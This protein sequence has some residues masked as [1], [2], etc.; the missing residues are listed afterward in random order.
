MAGMKTPDKP[1]H[2]QIHIINVKAVQALGIDPE[3]LSHGGDQEELARTLTRI[4]SYISSFAADRMAKFIL[5]SEGDWD[6]I[7]EDKQVANTAGCM[8]LIEPMLDELMS[9]G[10][11]I[12]WVEDLE[13][14]FPIT[15]ENQMA[16]NHD[17]ARVAGIEL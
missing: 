12:C 2:I 11:A 13:I 9:R 6:G 15:C 5:M 1:K 3:I 7:P 8:L 14:A 16:T 4:R 17:I 10:K